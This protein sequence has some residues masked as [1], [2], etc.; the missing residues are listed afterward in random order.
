[1]EGFES[2]F[3]TKPNVE[4]FLNLEILRLMK[5]EIDEIKESSREISVSP[6]SL[7][8]DGVISSSSK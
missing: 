6:R 3:L 4:L 1:L 2:F 5:D 7:Q 8:T